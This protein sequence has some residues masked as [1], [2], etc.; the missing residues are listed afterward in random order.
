LFLARRLQP[1]SVNARLYESSRARHCATGLAR[2]FVAHEDSARLR[3]LAAAAHV[4]IEA[5]APELVVE[6]A[7]G[8]ARIASDERR[9]A[10]AGPA[11]A[12]HLDDRKPDQR[13]VA[14]EELLGDGGVWNSP[15]I[16]EGSVYAA[17]RVWVLSFSDSS[18]ARQPQ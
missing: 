15:R 13:C 17:C 7:E 6:V 2:L 9:R 5:D 10:E 14:G 12:P 4:S 16:V 3:R 11:V 8:R 1:N 18:G